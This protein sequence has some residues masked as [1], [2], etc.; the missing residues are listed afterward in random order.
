[1]V[2]EIGG[3]AEESA[4]EFIQSKRVGFMPLQLTHL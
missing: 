2:G 1:M 4:A 3:T